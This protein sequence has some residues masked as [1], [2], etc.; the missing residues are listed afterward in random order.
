MDYHSIGD[1]ILETM[2][3]DEWLLPDRLYVVLTGPILKVGPP[4]PTDPETY[5]LLGD[6]DQMMRRLQKR[7]SNPNVDEMLSAM[8]DAEMKDLAAAVVRV[9]ERLAIRSDAKSIQ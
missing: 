8:S 9:G 6:L 7:L 3:N 4:W 5:R 1:V 2:K